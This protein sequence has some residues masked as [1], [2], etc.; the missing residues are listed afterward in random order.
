MAD[1]PQGVRASLPGLEFVACFLWGCIKDRVYKKSRMAE[2][3][4]AVITAEAARLPSEMVDITVSHLSSRCMP[5]MY[6]LVDFVNA[7]NRSF[8]M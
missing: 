5:C 2:A 7:R 6:I 3:V 4:K 1:E 8:F